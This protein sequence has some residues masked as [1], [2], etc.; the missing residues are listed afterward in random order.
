M[1]PPDV[2]SSGGY[3]IARAHRSDSAHD[4]VTTGLAPARVVASLNALGAG[5]LDF[6]DAATTTVPVLTLAPPR[7]PCASPGPDDFLLPT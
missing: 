1:I 2:L 3:G 5:F 7:G 4:A 6:L